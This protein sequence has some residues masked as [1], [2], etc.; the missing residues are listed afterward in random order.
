MTATIGIIL[1]FVALISSISFGCA[2]SDMMEAD[3]A[4]EKI[5]SDESFRAASLFGIGALLLWLFGIILIW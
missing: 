2:V 3:K 5:R 4:S 1:S